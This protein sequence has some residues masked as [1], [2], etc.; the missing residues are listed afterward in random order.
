M[1][2]GHLLVMLAG[3]TR[4]QFGVAPTPTK[5]RGA[6][7]RFVDIGD[8]SRPWLGTPSHSRRI[9]NKRRRLAMA[10]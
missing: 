2:L 8:R 7:P 6:L 5:G 1:Q 3:L 9:K 10:R 4:P